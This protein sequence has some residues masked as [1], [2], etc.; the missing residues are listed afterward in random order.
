MFNLELRDL[1]IGV[2]SGG[3][4]LVVVLAIMLFRQHKEIL[5]ANKNLQIK[6]EEISFQ[7]NAIESQA[8]ALL[9][10]N[11]EL[12]D[13]NRSLEGRINERT[14][15]LFL[16]NKK[17]AEYAFINA[18]KLRAPIASILGLIDLFS[19][20]DVSEQQLILDHLKTC[21]EDLDNT[22]RNINATL[23]EEA[24]DIVNSAALCG[25][26]SLRP[27]RYPFLCSTSQLPTHTVVADTL[28]LQY[29]HL[30]PHILLRTSTV[31]I[32][33]RTLS[34]PSLDF[35]TGRFNTFADHVV[36]DEV[37]A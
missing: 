33:K 13:L 27:L 8:E 4:L 18:H 9:K 3:L 34:P 11:E 7:K 24:G 19:K 22:I 28:I 32:L 2:V 17:L 26:I 12:H 14:K 21:G 30:H 29:F 35:H 37:G 25:Q 15:Q 23:E 16:Q 10:L 36:S 6:N 1:L 31:F 20:A 5:G